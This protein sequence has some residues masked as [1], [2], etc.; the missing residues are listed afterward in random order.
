MATIAEPLPPAHAPPQREQNVA[1]F[2]QEADV[3][4]VRD[5]L[6]LYVVEVALKLAEALDFEH[7]AE[8]SGEL[9]CEEDFALVFW[10][11]Y[12]HCS[13]FGCWVEGH[14]AVFGAARH[15]VPLGEE[16]LR[17]VSYVLVV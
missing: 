12:V 16:G 15:V 9:R 13:L 2:A 17:M 10:V 8:D 4:L 7:A 1:E 6:P 5:L 11:V 3:R 14:E